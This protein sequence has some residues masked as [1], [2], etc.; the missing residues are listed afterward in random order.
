M[1]REASH[2]HHG[3]PI[4][5]PAASSTK[6][7][8][9]SINSELGF[10]NDGAHTGTTPAK[11]TVSQRTKQP[12]VDEIA[13]RL[14]ERDL[15]IL[16]SVAEHQFLT[17]RQVEALNFADHAP[18]SGPRI[19]RRTLARL[20]NL[21]LLGT[22]QRRVG[23]M[24]AGSAGLVYYVDVVGDQLLNGR[25][26]RQSRRFQRRSYR[27]INHRLA[28]ADT[29]IRLIDADRTGVLELVNG[30]VEPAA[31]RR[32]TGIG[33]ARMTIKPDL[34]AE[35]AAADDLVHAWFIEVDLGTESIPTL[36]KKCHD[37]EAY[38]RI[39]IEQADG[40]GFPVVIW[41]MTDPDPATAEQRQLA[42]RE[43]I[44]S[45]RTLP[46][47][48]FRVIAPDQLV[49]LLQRGGTS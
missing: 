33:G 37:Y 1:R 25:S 47:A 10:P 27:F 18:V 44:A 23:G 48:L 13:S 9:T 30:A 6:P 34:Y 28:V 19:A 5:H 17:V 42:L 36:I 32:F 8:L 31:W 26:G 15:A 29:H 39:G 3:H 49:P 7:P 12:D 24:R 45:D 43:S 22:L 21:R 40:G 4:A 35:T 20:R 41:R 14:S 46:D 38:R 11:R 2:T 16:R